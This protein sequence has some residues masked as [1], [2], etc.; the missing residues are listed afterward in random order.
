MATM[1]M[2]IDTRIVESN[3]AKEIYISATPTKAAPVQD[4]ADETFRAIDE[5]LRSNQ[6]YLL[7]ERIFASGDTME[8]VCSARKES[9]RDLDDGV[10]PGLLVCKEGLTGPF[11]GVQVHAVASKTVPEVVRYQ[12]MSIGR[13]INLPSCHYLALSGISEPGSSGPDEQAKA[14]LRI[15]ESV[16]RRYG[17]D[18]NSVARTWMWLDDILSWYEDFNHV[19]STFFTEQRMLGNGRQDRMP[20]STGVGL[21]PANRSHC[22][23]DMVAVLEP[24]GSVRYSQAAGQQQSA[25][26]Y[27]SAFSRATRAV[28]PSSEIVYISGTASID[29]EGIT[30]NIGDIPGQIKA[31]I[32]NVRAVMEQMHC[33]EEKLVQVIAYCKNR[34]VERVFE[35]AKQQMQWP[36]VTVICDICRDDLLFEIEAAATPMA[37]PR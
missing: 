20:A 33:P 21:G 34:D 29:A 11:A 24:A 1:T 3:R 22:S 23:M 32:N 14:M 2:K 18:F 4:L 31:T 8:L 16:L 36:W 35:N 30:T 9:Y 6:A 17:A 12:E 7:Q 26:K 19:R 5:I 37:S 13:T 15:S 28:T 10:P 27:G 25:F